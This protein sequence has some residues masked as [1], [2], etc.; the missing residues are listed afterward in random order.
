M[1]KD[2]T[3]LE[4]NW[5]T[6]I[7]VGLFLLFIFSMFQEYYKGNARLRTMQEQILLENK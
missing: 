7:F 1:N 3:W 4:R 6:L 5:P 2:E